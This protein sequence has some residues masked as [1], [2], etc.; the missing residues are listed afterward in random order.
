MAGTSYGIAKS[1]NLIAVKVLGDNGSGTTADVI[2]GVNW[3]AAQHSGLITK[4]T[5]TKKKQAKNSI[6]IKNKKKQ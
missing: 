3:V 4:I 5:R 2:S 6:T 1:A